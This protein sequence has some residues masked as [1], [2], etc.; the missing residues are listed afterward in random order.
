MKQVYFSHSKLI[1]DTKE[2]TKNLSYLKEV[3]KC[4]VCPNNDMGEKGSISPYLK[5][6]EECGLVVALPY[7][8]F[9]GKGVFAEVEHALSLNIPVL[10]LEEKTFKVVTGVSTHD[11]TDWKFKYGKLELIK[12]E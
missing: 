3:F 2:E 12:W 8:K 6:I 7:K 10:M 11:D 5:M 9:I 4:V 1:Y